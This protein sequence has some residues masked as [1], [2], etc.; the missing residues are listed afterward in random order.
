MQELQTSTQFCSSNPC[1]PMNKSDVYMTE[2]QAAS[3]LGVSPRSLQRWR[4]SG[5]GPKFSKVGRRKVLYR[6]R[7]ISSYIDA[8]TY[9]S[10]AEAKL[11]M[12]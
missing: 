3:L 7:D 12:N 9:S 1:T 6:E 5:D 10:T 11:R 2:R 4:V 8:R